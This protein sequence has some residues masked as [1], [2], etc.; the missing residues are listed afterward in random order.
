MH[1]LGAI[2][3]SGVRRQLAIRRF[4]GLSS[5]DPN[6]H[7]A[8][9]GKNRNRLLN[10]EPIAKLLEHWVSTSDWIGVTTPT[11]HGSLPTQS[12]ETRS[13]ATDRALV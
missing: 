12:T 13:V 1:S 7:P 3:D 10:G 4:V 8:T 5:V 11:S 6:W 9:F 2:V